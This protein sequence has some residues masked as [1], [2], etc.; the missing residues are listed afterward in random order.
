MAQ[1]P[2]TG[3]SVLLQRIK[4]QDWVKLWENRGDSTT[5]LATSIWLPHPFTLD[6]LQV[7]ATVQ[8]R[9]EGR[10]EQPH[11]WCELCQSELK[12]LGR[13]QHLQC[14]YCYRFYAKCS[15]RGRSCFY[16]TTV[17][18][19]CAMCACVGRDPHEHDED[20]DEDEGP[21]AGEP[22]YLNFQQ[23]MAKQRIRCKLVASII[24]S[25]NRDMC[26]AEQY[27]LS[28]IKVAV[29]CSGEVQQLKENIYHSLPGAGEY[30]D[31]QACCVPED[32][33]SSDAGSVD[34]VIEDGLDD[35]QLTLGDAEVELQK[36]RILHVV[37]SALPIFKL[38]AEARFK[39]VNLRGV[40]GRV[41][42]W[43]RNTMAKRLF[44]AGLPA[45]DVVKNSR[46]GVCYMKAIRGKAKA[47]WLRDKYP[48]G[49]TVNDLLVEFYNRKIDFRPGYKFLRVGSR[50]HVVKAHPKVTLARCIGIVLKENQYSIVAGDVEDEDVWAGFDY[51]LDLRVEDVKLF[52]EP[53]FE[54]VERPA[55]VGGVGDCWK[56]LVGPLR[57]ALDEH[58]GG[59]EKCTVQDL[60]D[61]ASNLYMRDMMN[62]RSFENLYGALSD[63]KVRM[64]DQEDGDYH[65]A[66]AKIG[67][68]YRYDR[69]IRQQVE[70]DRFVPFLK[71][72][73]TA[74]MVVVGLQ[75]TIDKAMAAF[76]VP[77]NRRGNEALFVGPLS[78]TIIQAGIEAPY[79]IPEANQDLALKYGVA[80]NQYCGKWHPHPIHASLRI[81]ECMHVIPKYVK[82]DAVFISMSPANF[83]MCEGA[84][85][86]GSLSWRMINP[87]LDLKDFGRYTGT[88]TTPKVPFELPNFTEPTAVFHG[89]GHY[90][91]P[92]QV[93]RLGKANPTLR[94]MVITHVTPLEMYLT[95]NSFRSGYE[96]WEID[97]ENGTVCITLEGDDGGKYEQP[98]YNPLLF[99]KSI[100]DE[101]DP[102]NCWF[103]GVVETRSS[104][105]IQVWTRYE[106]KV[107]TKLVLSLDG[108]TILPQ[109][110]TSTVDVP[111]IVPINLYIAMYAYGKVLAGINTKDM[112]GKLRSFVTEKRYTMP[113][114]T[115]NWLIATIME[116][117]KWNVT[118]K[119]Q[120]EAYNSM[121][122]ELYYKTVGKLITRKQRWFEVRYAERMM[123][124]MEPKQRIYTFP[125]QDF[126]STSVEDDCTIYGLKVQVDPDGFAEA[127]YKKMY[128]VAYELWFGKQYQPVDLKQGTNFLCHH[129]TIKLPFRC[130]EMYRNS[131]ISME[132]AKDFFDIIER[133]GPELFRTEQAERRRAVHNRAEQDRKTLEE[134]HADDVEMAAEA[135][136]NEEFGQ[137]TPAEIQSQHAGYVDVDEV[138]GKLDKG[139]GRSSEVLGIPQPN[140]LR[141]VTTVD[142]DEEL[143]FLS[144]IVKQLQPAPLHRE[145]PNTCRDLVVYRKPILKPPDIVVANIVE[146]PKPVKK[147]VRFAPTLE[148]NI[149]SGSNVKLEDIIACMDTAKKKWNDEVELKVDAVKVEGRFD[150]ISNERSTE[151]WNQLMKKRPRMMHTY[152]SYSGKALW[153]VL[154]PKSVGKRYREIPYRSVKIY[155]KMPY[156]KNDCLLVAVYDAT[157]VDPARA[158]F[159]ACKAMPANDCDG[160]DLSANVLDPIGC[161]FNIG[162]IVKDGY[163]NTLSRHGVSEFTH[164]LIELHN[165]HYRALTKYQ[166]M[167]PKPLT[168]I[169]GTNV[170]KNV[171][172]LVAELS[173][174]P[175]IRF[176]PWRPEAARAEAYIRALRSG[177]TGLLG[178]T[179]VGEEI[180]RSWEENIY[181][182][183]KISSTR[184]IAVVEGSPGCRKSSAIQKVL[185]KEKWRTRRDYTVILPTNRLKEDWVPKICARD[186]N[187]MGLTMRQR[188]ICTFEKV[189]TTETPC[190][191]VVQDEDKFPKGYKATVA[192]INP[193]SKFFIHLG[194]RYQ[195]QRHEPNKDCLLNS[196][197]ML[198]EGDF[199]SQYSCKY[200]L[201]TWRFGPNI[202]NLFLLPT[203]S[204]DRGGIHFTDIPPANAS[205]LLEF[206]PWMTMD[207]AEVAFTHMGRYV[208]SHAA[209]LWT[210]EITGASTDTYAGSQGESV[211]V[212]L[213][214]LDN[215]AVQMSDY[216][217]GFTVMTRARNV[218]IVSKYDH[219]GVV[220]AA[221]QNNVFW[222]PILR[223]KSN[224]QKGKPV[225]IHRENCVDVMRRVGDL[226]DNVK[227]V[228]AGPPGKL[229]N[230]GFVEERWKDR[231]NFDEDYIDPDCVQLRGGGKLKYTDPAYVDSP[232]FKVH[233]VEHEEPIVRE[234]PIR[235]HLVIAPAVRTHTLKASLNEKMEVH[236][237]QVL[238]KTFREL[239]Y[240]GEYSN[241]LPDVYLFR[242]DV[243]Q[244][245]NNFYSNR[246]K[247]S[248][249][250]VL[251]QTVPRRERAK[252]LKYF[253]EHPNEDPR[254]FLPR[255]LSWGLDQKS[256]DNVSFSLGVLQRI[257]FSTEEKN[258]A[259]YRA[260]G[261]YGEALWMAMKHYLG[262]HDAVPW[263]QM[264]YDLAVQKFQNRRAERSEALKR[265]A[266]NRSDPD[267]E[268]FLTAKT[269][270]KLKEAVK[271]PAKPLQ[272][273]FVTAD[274]YIFK[275]GP[276]G[277]YML[278]K[279]LE[280]AP[281][282]W[283]MHAKKTMDDFELW[284]AR[285]PDDAEWV[286]NDLVGQ[287]QGMSGGYVQMFVRCMEHFNVPTDLIDYYVNS[288]LDFKTRTAVIGI[289]TLS[290]EIFT[291]LLNTLGSTSREC[292]KF[293]LQPG[294]PMA[295]G[296]DD[297]ARLGTMNTALDWSSWE[298]FDKCDDKRY[299]STRGEFVSF[300]VTKGRVLKN[301]EVLWLRLMGQIE[302]GNLDN[303]YL[304]Y[305]EHWARSYRLRE[306]LH[307][308][309]NENEMEYH[310]LLTN[311]FMNGQK[312]TSVANKANWRLV[313]QL[314][315]TNHFAERGSLEWAELN[316]RL[317]VEGFE[318]GESHSQAFD[319]VETMNSF[320]YDPGD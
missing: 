59:K 275:M 316:Q 243:K 41:A 109:V 156:P 264:D 117:L 75:S 128:R 283:Y 40:D 236:D 101:T 105:H 300:I 19:Q 120:S 182:R 228:L 225:V 163:S 38:M 189:L 22:R 315:D 16:S 85:S 200:L 6:P 262:W 153:D 67:P 172:D 14:T 31:L 295:N 251:R 216:R 25:W 57:W 169:I 35:F 118:P 244:V 161:Y 192:L 270:W 81:W 237:S 277:I 56:K 212:A 258:W 3:W 254:R 42:H 241:Q 159:A 299:Q 307:S 261:Q 188:Q 106:L 92:T 132:K 144:K 177:T 119:L 197:D 100:R 253:D 280:R 17:L 206:L 196:P 64:E 219:H 218:I 37:E 242:K 313:R 72:L 68:A 317:I 61:A 5:Q 298:Q 266:L 238:F 289:M 146:E 286:I 278:E 12:D 46:S 139:K 97:R 235:E 292:L 296:G 257:N 260:E 137:P 73:E 247:K 52:P 122:G 88:M 181:H 151:T 99:A 74:R 142:V 131:G 150:K 179:V 302:R 234:A 84:K 1:P 191:V 34:I 229:K 39:P 203:F 184:Y 226:P 157:G 183:A 111:R 29:S 125:L 195:S 246:R 271:K 135:A 215:A 284:A 173:S 311:F 220:T 26:E 285:L 96:D 60:K 155:P 79:A 170:T 2:D 55:V 47:R 36:R 152:S 91:L 320:F 148:P 221:A 110:F 290:G 95:D 263:D 13:Y 240:K 98:F 94:V 207:E 288:K 308:I 306:E 230:R 193:A 43:F 86:D 190:S 165:E 205:D 202:A 168:T 54:V 10:T 291:Y 164:V 114:A 214:T 245:L 252:H 11:L 248:F 83:S 282:Y 176:H 272:T 198:G 30:S 224:Y 305:F 303:C 287:D 63:L 281:P 158:L 274:R 222:G 80:F 126:I 4:T 310:N 76:V 103:G 171:M 309:Y 293:N 130:V 147:I 185:R 209:K 62:P 136:V 250:Q 232:D 51:D 208:P 7:L 124:L 141:G 9:V 33:A 199:Y 77:D 138:I 269:Q 44:R 143:Q 279:I 268:G 213:V 160:V 233:I 175:V 107:P 174:L 227:I 301:P 314:E 8:D 24:K 154:Y 267:F 256:S 162:F 297:T 87:I 318:N 255:A 186:K 239:S 129:R 140:H 70:D 123:R 53:K 27:L 276:L 210:E 249:E 28:K 65:M 20:S 259:E 223:Y 78:E 201:G 18:D 69:K 49:V 113:L 145:L 149:A 32:C 194:D 312:Y 102:D 134:H 89:S 82:T 23:S 116:L 104:H 21:V 112:W 90:M 58:L 217:I 167:V 187:S 178:Q 66:D 273:I 231:V 294:V 211:D 304:G 93:L 319:A 180:L 127:Q 204:N 48:L 108:F 133:R 166:P 50:L 121:L 115:Q 45:I 265:M 71:F 15:V